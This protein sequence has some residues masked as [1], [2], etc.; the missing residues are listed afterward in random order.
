M[1]KYKS[2]LFFYFLFFFI[3]LSYN[4]LTYGSEKKS[5]SVDFNKCANEL[6]LQQNQI[7][8][9]KVIIIKSPENFPPLPEG[10]TN[11]KILFKYG[12]KII[13]YNNEYFWV[14]ATE[15]DFIKS[16]AERLNIDPEQVNLLLQCYMVDPRHCNETSSC[17]VG[18]RYGFCKTA[19]NSEERYYYCVCDVP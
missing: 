12:V 19:Y 14:A 18:T 13:K 3:F 11:N 2:I 7:K 8:Q 5:S 1:K 9:K 16:E 4:G 10:L 15:E 6:D 17:N